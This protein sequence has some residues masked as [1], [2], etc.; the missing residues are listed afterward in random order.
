FV[1][2]GTHIEQ[3]KLHAKAEIVLRGQANSSG[4]AR[5]N[6]DGSVRP[7]RPPRGV[8]IST[9]ED[10]PRGQSLVA[11]ML[12]T[13]VKQGDVDW[14][15]LTLSQKKRREGVFA[16]ATSAFLQWL[17]T[18]NRIEELQKKAAD[19]IHELRTEWAKTGHDIH[20]KASNTLAQLQ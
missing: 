3:A 6:P 13:E 2:K 9:G 14:T 10:I 4:R 1:P 7:E 5:C 18:D 11:R 8:I 15:Q 20:K 16:E 19:K 12:A 17:A